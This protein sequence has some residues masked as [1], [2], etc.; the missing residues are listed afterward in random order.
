M[1]IFFD[2][3]SPKPIRSAI[4]QSLAD[5]GI[6][7]CFDGSKDT[8]HREMM[9]QVRDME[10]LTAPPEIDHWEQE[11][12]RFFQQQA[13]QILADLDKQTH[14]VL[15][16]RDMC[17]LLPLWLSVLEKPLCILCLPHTPL[18][19]AATLQTVYDCP[20]PVG[21]ALWEL[22]TKRLLELTQDL[23]RIIIANESLSL[24]PQAVAHT[25]SQ[26]LA[27]MGYY[28]LARTIRQLG[29]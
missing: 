3:L 19:F 15:A 27:A 24:N 14:V 28:A 16:D 20:L 18:G 11:T 26:Q 17:V 5:S 23:P 7:I 25:L 29:A 9:R 8:L 1:V 22:W 12:V 10:W 13:R 2:G 21:V 6:P 4:V